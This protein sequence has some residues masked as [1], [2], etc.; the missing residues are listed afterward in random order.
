M[1]DYQLFDTANGV[2]AIAWTDAGV[3]GFRLPAESAERTERSLLRRFPGAVRRA[4]PPEIA[5]AIAA[6]QRYFEGEEIDFSGVKVD[7][8]EQAPFFAQIYD[9]VRRLG[10]GQ[11]TTYGAVAKELGAG[12]ES[13]RA[14]G[15]AMASNPVPLIVPCHRVL[16]AGGKVG[17]FSAPGGSDSKVKM[18]AIEGIDLSPPEPAQQG[19]FF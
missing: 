1:A 6:A 12:P 16:A 2:A 3:V 19:F 15:Q 13:A 5:A 8:G 14:V 18:L 9:S 7:L 10:W 11:T 4:P 17:G